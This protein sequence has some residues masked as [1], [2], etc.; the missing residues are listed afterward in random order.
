MLFVVGGIAT[1]GTLIVFVLELPAQIN[2]FSDELPILREKWLNATHWTGMYSSNPEGIVNMAELDLSWKSDVDIYLEYLNESHVIDGYIHSDSFCQMGLWY[3][4]VLLKGT[5][6]IWA[7]DRLNLDVYE[8]V[9]GHTV[10]LDEIRIDREVPG[11]I[12]TIRSL[13]SKGIIIKETLRLAPNTEPI[14]KELDWLCLELNPD[15][16]QTVPRR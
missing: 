14:E 8:I 11:G 5:P 15:K 2:Q 6:E 3:R 1:I 4:N 13:K 16:E 12:I 10:I 9:Q 7:P